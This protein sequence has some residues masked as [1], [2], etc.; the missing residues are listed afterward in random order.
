MIVNLIPALQGAS[1]PK[2]E[3]VCTVTFDDKP[4]KT[5]KVITNVI[6]DNGGT[7]K[8]SDFDISIVG[9]FKSVPS[10]FTGSL[11]PKRVQQLNYIQQA[12]SLKSEVLY[13]L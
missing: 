5:L 8:E 9:P 2:T 4:Y 1:Y 10:F 12:V 13:I 6:N 11:G 7:K 3:L